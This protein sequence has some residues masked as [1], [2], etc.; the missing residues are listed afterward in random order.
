MLLLGYIQAALFSAAAAFVNPEPPT[1]DSEATCPEPDTQAGPWYPCSAGGGKLLA[2]LRVSALSPDICER[3][4]TDTQDTEGRISCYEL[5]GSLGC[6][7]IVTR[8]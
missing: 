6:T 5:R 8:E 4:V 3:W 7:E 2:Y 1:E